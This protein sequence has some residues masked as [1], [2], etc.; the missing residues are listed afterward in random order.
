VLLL[1]HSKR[2]IRRRRKPKKRGKAKQMFEKGDSIDLARARKEGRLPGA[3][4]QGLPLEMR[5]RRIGMSSKKKIN[6]R[7][8]I[9]PPR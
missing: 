4:E 8:Y 3:G 2:E 6:F 7:M 1:K 5:S 9:L